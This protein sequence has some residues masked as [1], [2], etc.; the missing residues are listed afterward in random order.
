MRRG[1][2][3]IGGNS[4]GR[5]FEDLQGLY[6]KFLGFAFSCWN[7]ISVVFC[8]VVFELRSGGVDQLQGRANVD[9][10]TRVRAYVLGSG[11]PNREVGE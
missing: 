9:V 10:T 1:S 2:C 11:V 3:K 8:V 7:D 6:I 5:K 4:S